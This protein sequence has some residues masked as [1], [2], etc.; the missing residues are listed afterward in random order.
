[1][2][3]IK[4]KECDKTFKSVDSVR[5]HR[6]LKHN[7]S[8]EDTYIDYVLGSIRPTCKCGCGGETKYL[9]IKAGYRDYV[10]GHASR[11]NN[12]WGHNLEAI[13]KSH[14]TQK[15]MYESGELVVWNKGLDISDPRVKDN[16]DKMLSNPERGNNISKA[17]SGVEKSEEHRRK[18]SESANVRWSDPKE[19]EKQRFRRLEYFTTKQFNVKSKLEE[20]F[21]NILITLNIEFE[22]QHPINGY[23]YDF[24]VPTKN[25]LLEVDGDWY[26]FNCK[27][28]KEP[29]SPIQENTIKND[30][31]KNKL[32]KKLGYNLV[33][34]WEADINEN[35]E[36]VINIL[37]GLA[38]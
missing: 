15:V 5:R 3:N 24:Y 26:H 22:P 2:E 19:R 9:G 23:L 20:K 10:R 16:I 12:N 13:R 38:T 35:T 8:A 7:V 25:L 37:K 36:N 30:K 21:E 14:E 32:A 34:F 17:L 4:C 18:L 31:I 11:V 28:H 27:V 33:R 29:L 1:M 6:A